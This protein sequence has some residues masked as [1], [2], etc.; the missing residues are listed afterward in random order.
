MMALDLVC[1]IAVPESEQ[2]SSWTS[3][4]GAGCLENS[5]IQAFASQIFPKK[6]RFQL[7][8]HKH[9]IAHLCESTVL[10]TWR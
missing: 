8:M 10:H 6:E 1:P 9:F 2:S 4:S 7:H 3:M 5:A